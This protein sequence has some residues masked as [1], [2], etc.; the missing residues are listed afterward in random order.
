[1]FPYLCKGIRGLAGIPPVSTLS[2]NNSSLLPSKAAQ[3]KI[4]TIF[5]WQAD[6]A[7][8]SEAPLPK[9]GEEVYTFRPFLVGG[10]EKRSAIHY[11]STHGLD[12]VL[13]PS[14]QNMNYT[15]NAIRHHFDTINTRRN[16]SE[17]IFHDIGV[18][19]SAVAHAG[20]EHEKR[21]S[22]ML[23]AAVKQMITKEEEL[24]KGAKMV[25]VDISELRK[26][27]RLLVEDAL[28]D[29]IHSM[30][31]PRHILSRKRKPRMKSIEKLYDTLLRGKKCSTHHV[32]C[33]PIPKTKGKLY[34]F[35]C[36]L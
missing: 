17:S 30:R 16:R 22:S 1:M 26:H 6:D 5:D 11:C 25:Q 15:R 35:E 24:A 4:K 21:V 3:V 20:L 9:N 34:I 36:K 28:L 14:N 19:Q 32:H 18:V 8:S 10:I 33:T 13:D 31:N 2:E 7:I 23:R 12:F 29:L 27:P